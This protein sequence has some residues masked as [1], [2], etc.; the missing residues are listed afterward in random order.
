VLGQKAV[1]EPPVP[2]TYT[3]AELARMNLLLN[4]WASGCVIESRY[5][6]D[7]TRSPHTY[8]EE[9]RSLLG[10]PHRMVRA[11]WLRQ[12]REQLTQLSS[13][14]RQ[15]SGGRLRVP[16]FPDELE[17]TATGGTNAL[18]VDH[19]YR[20]FVTGGKVALYPR[21]G[22][23][24]S[25]DD[26]SVLTIEGRGIGYLDMVETVPAGDWFVVPLL[27]CEKQLELMPKLLT[28]NV[29][30]ID[31]DF[32]E[33][34]GESALPPI[35]DDESWAGYPS[36]RGYP[37]VTHVHDWSDGRDVSKVRYGSDRE[38]GRSRIV[39]THGPRAIQRSTW[40][41]LADREMFWK[42]L[43]LF[44]GCRGRAGA[45]WEVDASPYRVVDTDPTFIDVSPVGSFSE[46]EDYVRQTDHVGIILDDGSVLDRKVTT[47]QQ[48]AGVWRLTLDIGE[49]DLP[50]DQVGSFG[51]LRL[52]RFYEDLLTEEWLTTEVVRL[53]F[54]T[55]EI[56]DE[57][58][59]EL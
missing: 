37:I 14:L 57:E 59:Y 4:N 2:L 31:I 20:R 23:A 29:V 12:S 28:D 9:R 6:T 13:I 18:Q 32:D 47:I 55:V 38:T 3:A 53:R 10:R 34:P 27:D 17:A 8:A 19:T 35:V 49:A 52:C 15:L 7:V 5:E 45:F 56:L 58:D 25:V 22:T 11:H 40:N 26:V 41:V 43:S 33:V 48:I 44:D 50:V 1:W 54:E 16:V 36:T 24:F 21:S 51:V 46:F 42:V 39:T 30:Q